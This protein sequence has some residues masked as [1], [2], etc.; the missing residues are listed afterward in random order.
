VIRKL[1]LLH[2]GIGGLAFL[3]VAFAFGSDVSGATDPTTAAL[4]LI[5]CI[6]PAASLA[7]GIG[8]IR[9]ERWGSNVIT[10]LSGIYLFAFP[11]GTL[12]GAFGLWVLIFRRPEP[13]I[14]HE[15]FE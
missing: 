2:I 11:L 15:E 3:L 4:V 7:G 8:L 13:S 1:A 9:G 5:L 10:V 12:L 14:V 6:L